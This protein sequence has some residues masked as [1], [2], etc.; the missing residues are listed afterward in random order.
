MIGAA[1]RCGS[2]ASIL[3]RRRL[4]PRSKNHKYSRRAT[5]DCISN[6][7]L[8]SSQAPDSQNDAPDSE[9]K[10]R[11]T[12]KLENFILCLHG[13]FSTTNI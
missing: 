11:M 8:T 1:F 6:F 9:A 3:E 13:F 10:S 12:R 7:G 4:I 2:E 5:V